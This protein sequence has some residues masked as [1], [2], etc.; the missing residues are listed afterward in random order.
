MGFEH[1]SRAKVEPASIEDNLLS[2]GAE[3]RKIV[4]DEE[5]WVELQ[6]RPIAGRW[7]RKDQEPDGDK[8]LDRSVPIEGTAVRLLHPSDNMIQVCLHTAKHSYVRAPGLRLHTDVD[9]LVKYYPPEWDEVV[10]IARRLAIRTPV[11]FSLFFARQLLETPIPD[12]V[13]ASLHPG[14]WKHEVVTR[15]L[16]HVG[17]FQPDEKKFSR[18]GMLLFHSLLY[19]DFRGMCAS[20]LGTVPSAMKFRNTPSLAISAVRRMWDLSTRYQA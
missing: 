18:P 4:D 13:L 2:G 15:W 10:A 5:V 8:L 17:F 9:R 19:D 16:K 7:I 20:M 12:Y 1:A 6:W 11:F 14:R 3:Y